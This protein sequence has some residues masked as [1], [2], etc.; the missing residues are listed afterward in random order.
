LF[1]GFVVLIQKM[2]DYIADAQDGL[3]AQCIG[4]IVALCN[5]PVSGDG[6]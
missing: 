5:L 6:L 4:R 2:A 1:K 3:G